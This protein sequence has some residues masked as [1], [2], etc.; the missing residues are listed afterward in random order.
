MQKAHSSGAYLRKP[1]LR[2]LVLPQKQLAYELEKNISSM[3]AGR[4][5]IEIRVL[6]GVLQNLRQAD[7]CSYELNS[8][9]KQLDEYMER[10]IGAAVTD[11]QHRERL[12]TS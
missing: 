5:K 3:K 12:S 7:Q 11:V 8:D 9:K 2:M 4:F 6:Q 10:G 1:E